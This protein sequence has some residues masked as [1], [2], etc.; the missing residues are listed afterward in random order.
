MR[1]S[2]ALPPLLKNHQSTKTGLFLAWSLTPPTSL[3][4]SRHQPARTFS[5]GKLSKAAMPPITE[6]ETAHPR[7]MLTLKRVMSLYCFNPSPL[8]SGD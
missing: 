3:K 7:L 1:D 6:G 4:D 2:G 8:I 5:W